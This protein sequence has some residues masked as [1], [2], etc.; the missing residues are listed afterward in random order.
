MLREFAIGFATTFKHIFKKPITVNYPDQKVPMFPKYRGKQ[1]LMRDENGL[2]KCVACGLCAVACPADAIYLEA[3]ENDGSVQAGPRYAKVYQ[4]H[5]TRCIFCG[6]CEEACPVSRDLHGQGLRAGRLQQ[7]RLHLG[8]GGPARA[9]LDRR[10]GRRVDAAGRRSERSCARPARTRRSAGPTR[11]PPR[12]DRTMLFGVIADVHGNFEAM[13]LAMRGHPDVPFWLCVGDLASR[14][15]VYPNRR[16]R[17][18]GSRATTRTSTESAAMATGTRVIANLHYIPNGT[19][20]RVGPLTVAGLGGTYAPTLVSLRRRGP[21]VSGARR[22]RPPRRSGRPGPQRQAAALRARGGRCAAAPDARG[23]PADAR[24]AAAVLRR[25]RGRRERAADAATPGRRR[26]TRSSRP[27]AR[28]CISADTTTGTRRTCTRA[29][30]RCAWTA[31]RALI[32]SST[33]S[34]FRWRKIDLPQAA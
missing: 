3:A 13:R 30:R 14:A 23:H 7:E 11:L 26:S 22:R 10:R 18:T 33:P 25:G 21:A 31:S 8:Q 9:G 12:R 5:K 6:Y 28:V 24:G 17:S 15:G 16:R 2:E 1:V 29:C 27:C 19:A 32:W 4:I 20:T 34:T